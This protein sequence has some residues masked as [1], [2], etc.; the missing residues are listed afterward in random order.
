MG[1]SGCM[2]RTTISDEFPRWSGRIT[3]LYDESGAPVE[4]AVW[5]L[6]GD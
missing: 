5:G 4:S 1:A 6:Y 2:Y 3:T